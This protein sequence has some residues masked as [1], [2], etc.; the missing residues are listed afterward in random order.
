VFDEFTP[1]VTAT[2]TGLFF[3]F[4][5]S[6]RDNFIFQSPYIGA[7]DINLLCFQGIEGGCD[8]NAGPHESIAIDGDG[9]RVQHF[10]GV[11][12]FASS[13]PVPTVP[14]PQNVV[15]VGTGLIGLLV[16]ASHASRRNL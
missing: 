2:P 13:S 10:S 4:S 15:L 3:D 12:E 7:F 9:Q 14:E 6:S 5:N 11:V 1:L 16:I 8:D